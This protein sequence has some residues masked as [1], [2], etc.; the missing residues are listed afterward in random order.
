V[1][2]RSRQAAASGPMFHDLQALREL[3]SRYLAAS[4]RR[5]FWGQSGS[6]L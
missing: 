3:H 2:F 5:S 6:P 4:R 1:Q